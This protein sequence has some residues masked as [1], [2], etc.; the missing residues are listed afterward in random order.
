MIEI[1]NP[2]FTLGNLVATPGVI[3]GIDR[4]RAEPDGFSQSACSRSWAS[5]VR[6]DK[7]TKT[8]CGM[9]KGYFLFIAH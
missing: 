4:I 3:G 9:A 2:R 5:A 1:A 7:P 6:I 8:P